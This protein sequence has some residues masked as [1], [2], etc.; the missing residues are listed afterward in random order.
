MN[1]MGDNDGHPVSVD[2]GGSLV[3]VEESLKIPRLYQAELLEEAKKR[4]IIIRAD[5]GTGKTLVALNLIVWTAAQTESAPNG[6]Q[7]QAFLV[8]T[9]P[10]VHQ[11]AEYIQSQSTLRIKAYAGDL[12]ADLWNV[13]KWRSELKEVDVIVSTAQVCYIYISFKT[14]S[15]CKLLS[16]ILSF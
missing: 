1:I 16:L 5:T 14:P 7:I 3:D 13:D 4:N 12:P 9:R 8:P 6:H 15:S 2:V 10:L 11:Q